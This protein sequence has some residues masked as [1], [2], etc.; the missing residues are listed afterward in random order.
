MQ[1]A[2]SEKRRTEPLTPSKSG[3]T[4]AMKRS[5]PERSDDQQ[6]A[7]AD[8]ASSGKNQPGTIKHQNS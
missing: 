1:H 5:L 6:V 2:Q 4:A 7:A 8:V 3:G